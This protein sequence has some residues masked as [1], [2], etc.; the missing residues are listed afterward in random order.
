MSNGLEPMSPNSNRVSSRYEDDKRIDSFDNGDHGLGANVNGI[1]ESIEGVPLVITTAGR[2]G[3]V[4]DHLVIT[5][6][7]GVTIEGIVILKVTI[8]L[9]LLK[10][11]L[12]MPP[13]PRQDTPSL[14]I[15]ITKSK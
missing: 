5:A 12:T 13:P 1:H 14:N 9:Q 11:T 10:E 6:E 8:P 15:S 7:D 4:G 3:I 2:Q